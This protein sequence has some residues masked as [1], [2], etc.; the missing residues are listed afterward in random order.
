M[1]LDQVTSDQ[2]AVVVSAVIGSI[3]I[4]TVGT[5]WKIWT[6]LRLLMMRY[7]NV[8]FDEQEAKLGATEADPAPDLR[9]AM[10]ALLE[11]SEEVTNDE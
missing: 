3:A 8:W 4:S 11:T 10:D 6:R 1:F 9:T 5:L 7:V 2:I